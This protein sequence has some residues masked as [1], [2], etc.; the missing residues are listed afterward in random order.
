MAMILNGHVHCDLHIGNWGIRNYESLDTI[1]I[2][3]YDFGQCANIKC[4]NKRRHAAH[5]FITN[6]CEEIV[7][8]SMPSE[9]YPMI[10]SKFTDN[11]TDNARYFAS[12]TL[13]FYHGEDDDILNI[14][15]AWG[16]TK[17]TV[18]IKQRLI[19]K[20]NCIDTTK[21]LSIHGRKA[22]FETHFPF[23]EFDELKNLAT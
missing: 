3:L 12:C 20:H 5:G 7:V 13:Q 8:N 6:N 14:L 2:V 4:L 23:V 11:F 18:D 17:N 10:L 15:L 9:M 22:Y 21:F 1:Q 19:T 16:K